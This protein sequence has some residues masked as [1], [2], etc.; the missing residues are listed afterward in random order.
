[1]W[2]RI[3][4]LVG[5]LCLALAASRTPAAGLS[6]LTGLPAYPN[7]SNPVMDRLAHTDLLGRWCTRFSANTGDSIDVVAEWYRKILA[8]A[9]ETDLTHD[10]RY[11]GYLQLAGIKLAVGID[12]VAVFKISSQAPTSIELYRCSPV[13]L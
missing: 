13:T 8:T 3:S 1:M 12:Y 7:L 11:G 2:G 6:N 5:G 4:W 9:S 10:R